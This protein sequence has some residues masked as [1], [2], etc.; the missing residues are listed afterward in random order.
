VLALALALA[1]GGTACPVCAQVILNAEATE[2]RDTA[3]VHVV[4]RASGGFQAGN[5][6]VVQV[7]GGGAIGYRVG[8]QWLRLMG[9]LDYLGSADS[10]LVDSRYVHVRYS[11]ILTP[12][13]RTF[14]FWQLQSN[15]ALLLKRR[16]LLGT[17][18]R[19]EVLRR[20]GVHAAI[21]TGVM[22]EW[23]RAARSRSA[24]GDVVRN[25]AV[26]MANLA[27]LRATLP[28]KV[29]VLSVTYFQPSLSAPSDY[30]ALS[31][32]GLDVPLAGFLD[33]G[34]DLEWRHDSRPPVGVEP[35]DVAL[36]TTLTLLR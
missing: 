18:L 27:V 20:G 4:L 7:T 14:H 13:L 16:A 9:G 8:R 3:G 26:R 19:L 6:R 28:S 29:H 23:E 25:T 15:R 35:D 5:A 2:P 36:R 21:G 17:G 32:L 34:V 11:I 1:L 10:S 31:D 24:P 22:Y 12:R 30:R 33:V